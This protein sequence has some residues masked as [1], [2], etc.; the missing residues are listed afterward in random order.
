MLKH[1][2]IVVAAA[3]VGSVVGF[4]GAIITSPLWGWFEEQTGIESLGHSGPAT[5]V[6]EFMGGICVAAVFF[7]LEWV[8][9]RRRVVERRLVPR[10][11][12]P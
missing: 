2:L 6:F 1:V 8:F 11:S 12:R 7:F 10:S 4:L 3:V 9:R 5:W